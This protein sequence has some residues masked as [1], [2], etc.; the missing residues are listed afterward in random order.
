[1]WHRNV[2]LIEFLQNRPKT[3]N[4]FYF[5]FRNTF[6]STRESGFRELIST[7]LSTARKTAALANHCWINRNT[8]LTSN[9]VFSRNLCYE[10]FN[11]SQGTN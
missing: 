6:H 4:N 7:L 8:I 9:T 2:H 11:I 5:P 3:W 1:M 10:R